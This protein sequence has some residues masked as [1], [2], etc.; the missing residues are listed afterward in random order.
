MQIYKAIMPN[1]LS[2]CTE[3]LLDKAKVYPFSAELCLDCMLGFNSNKL[4]EDEIKLVYDNYL[5]ISPLQ[6]IGCSK[7]TG[8]IKTLIKFFSPNEY[9]VEI[10]CSEGYLL[11]KLKDLGYK[12][13]IGIEPGPQ[14]DTASGLGLNIIKGFYDE[15]TFSGKTVDGFYLMHVFEHLDMPLLKLESMKMQLSP[16]GKIVIEVPNFEGF[17]HHHL[18]FYNTIFL[19]NLCKRLS[20]KIIDKSIEMDALRIVIAHA[21]NNLYDEVII[22]EDRTLIIEN[23]KNS[24]NLFI[25]QVEQI[26]EI[27]RENSGKQIYWWGAGSTSVI[28]LNQIDKGILKSVEIVILDGDENK[29]GN[30][31]PGINLKVNSFKMIKNSEVENL[32]IATQFFNEIQVTMRNN[33]IQA[34]T[35]YSI[36]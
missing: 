4:D 9:I 17:H 25:N 11:K 18:F 14:A 19:N 7:Y 2:A 12:N 31:I 10:G 26:S 24:Y 6:G 3:G 21:D 8:M 5:Y 33:N 23:S 15:N 28:F 16:L 1:I 34:K 27:M 20:L 32:I 22:D 36:Y 13:L 35:I 29:H 30:Y